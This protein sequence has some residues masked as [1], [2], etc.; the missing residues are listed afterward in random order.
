MCI[1]TWI[2]YKVNVIF[3]LRKEHFPVKVINVTLYTLYYNLY[4]LL[5][6][7]CILYYVYTIYYVC[8]LYYIYTIYYVCILYYVYTIQYISHIYTIKFTVNY[9]LF[10][11][12]YV[13]LHY[14]LMYLYIIHSVIVIQ[15]TLIHCC[16]HIQ[17][18]ALLTRVTHK[19]VLE[20]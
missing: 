15:Y 5:M 16:A 9:T 20:K 1:K 6:F 18:C 11:T 12:L 19:K 14:K 13:S 4:I 10:Y 7:V 8:V 3:P 2:L 17:L